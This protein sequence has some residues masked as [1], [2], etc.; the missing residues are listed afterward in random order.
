MER[1]EIDALFVS[2]PANVTY[3]TGCTVWGGP[4][5]LV[6]SIAKEEPTF[7]IRGVDWAAGIYQSFLERENLITYP[8]NRR[9]KPDMEATMR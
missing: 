2:N 9:F 6:V 3:L 4:Q 5:G 1:L 8:E 7:I